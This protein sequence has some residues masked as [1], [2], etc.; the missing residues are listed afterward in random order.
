[1]NAHAEII[2]SLVDRIKKTLVC[3]KMPRQSRSS[4]LRCVGSSKA[5]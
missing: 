1:M 4:M 5:R 3:L 2:P